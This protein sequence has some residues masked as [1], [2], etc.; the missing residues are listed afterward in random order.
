MVDG[1]LQPDMVLETVEILKRAIE[2]GKVV[3]LLINNRAGSNAPLIAE[4]IAEKF[5]EKN[6]SSTQ[7]QLNL[8]DIYS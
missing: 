7:H 5:I 4:E 3:N 8:W 6:E 1:M 2:Q